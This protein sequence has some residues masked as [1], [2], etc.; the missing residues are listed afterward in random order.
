[1][2][3]NQKVIEKLKDDPLMPLRHTAEHVLHT[4][5]QIMYPNIKKV[6]GPPIENGFYFDFDPNGEIISSDDFE[7]IEAKMQEIIDAALE[8]QKQEVTANDAKEIFA[9]NPY[10]LETIKEIENRKEKVTLYSIGAAGNKFYDLDLCAGPHIN[11]TKNIKAFKLLS[12]A[13]AYYKGD[14]DNK[15]LTRIYG[16]AFNSQED[17]DAYVNAIEEQ[18]ANDHRE[19]NKVLDIYATSELV[20]KGLIMYTPNGTIIKNE[21]KNHLL[22]ICKKHGAQE[23][24]IPHMAKIDLY[25][26]SGHAEKFKE[27]LFKVVSHYD[28]EFVL[29]PVNCPHH[30]QIYASRPRS[31]RDLPIAYVE[32]TQQHRD[33]KPGAMVGLNRARSFEIDDG[34]TFCT[35]EQIKDEAIKMVHIMKEFYEVFGMWGK[36][37]VSLSFRDKSTPEKYI[38]DDTGWNKAENMLKEIND[39]LNLGGRIMEGEAALYGPKIDIMLKDALGNDRQLGTVQIDFA[40]PKRFGLTYVDSDGTE[41]TPVMLHRAILGS[42]HRF[43]ANLLESTKGSLP[44]WLAPTQVIIIPVS[45]KHFD[46]ADKVAQQFREKDLRVQVNKKDGTMGAKIRE[47]Q[48]EKTPYMAIVGDREEENSEISIRLRTGENKNGLNLNNTVEKISEVYKTKTQKLDF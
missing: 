39:E 2:S 23:V 38:G 44:V 22:K 10:K 16:T 15:M 3:A 41:K 13:G 5:M 7:K 18:K 11:N 43:I 31:Y 32:S 46:Y 14:E 17:L 30:T 9:D 21:L 20:G 19:L 48:L 26:T 47:A 36:H 40:M 34:H 28:E 35:P 8:I 12:V 42:Y 1:M 4:A 6:M 37:W 25:K 27:E 45:E 24:D 29:K 33:E